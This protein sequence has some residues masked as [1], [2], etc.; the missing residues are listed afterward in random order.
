MNDN[1]LS[2]RKSITSIAAK[3]AR[4]HPFTLVGITWG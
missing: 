4:A 2:L 3:H 1:K